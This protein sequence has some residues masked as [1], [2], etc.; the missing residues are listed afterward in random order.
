MPKEFVI[1]HGGAT[2]DLFIVFLVQLSCLGH[3]SLTQQ[4]LMKAGAA[5]YWASGIVTANIAFRM[6]PRRG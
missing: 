4:I 2:D 1:R 3:A 6:F 5:S